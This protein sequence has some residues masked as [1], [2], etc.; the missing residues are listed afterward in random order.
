LTIDMRHQQVFKHRVDDRKKVF[1]PRVGNSYEALVS[2][3]T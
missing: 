3:S 2:F 1:G